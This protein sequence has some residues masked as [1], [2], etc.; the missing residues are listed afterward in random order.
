LTSA[1]TKVGLGSFLFTY[2]FFFEYL[3]PFRR[4]HIPGDLELYHYPLADYAFQMLKQGRFPLW[5]PSTYCGMSFVGNIQAA[6]FYP[7][8]WLMFATRWNHDRLSYQ[9]VETMALAHVWLAFFLCYL[10]LRGNRLQELACMLGAGVFAYSGYL[11]SQL[12]HLGML[13]GYAWIPLGLWGIDQAKERRSW[14]PLWKVAAASALC[15]LAGYPPTWIVFAVLTGFYALGG[16]W[17]WPVAL[18]FAASVAVSLA[19][20][21][22]QVLPTMEATALREPELRYAGTRE[23]VLLLAFTLPNYIDFG[24]N[25]P[26][27]ENPFA[28]YL[29]LGLPG[30]L[31]IPLLIRAR[32]LKRVAP[33]AAMGLASAVMLTNPFDLVGSVVHRS[34]L[35]QDV[36][37]G[38]NLLAGVPL[39]FAAL[40]AFA[41][42][43]FLTRKTRPAATWLKWACVSGLALWA[44][45]DL[46][47]WVGPGFPTGWRASF[48]WMVALLLFAAGLYVVRGQSG[49]ARTCTIA[50]LTVFVGVDYKVF[51]TSKRFNAAPGLGQHYSSA[52]YHAMDT[53]AYQQLRAH[54]QARILLDLTGPL[55]SLVR[56]IGLLTPQ[57]FDPFMSIEFRKLMQPVAHFRSERDFDVYL[58]NDAALQ[59]LGVRYVISSESGPWYPQLVGSPKFRLV[60][61]KRFFY[62]VFEY[63]QARPPYGWESDDTS[64][65]VRLDGWTP[66]Q[67]TF[68]VRSLQGGRF[69]LSEQ[70][71][72]GWTVSID[73]RRATVKRWRG[74]FQAVEAPGGEHTIVFRFREPWLGIGAGISLISLLG[75]AFWVGVDSVNRAKAKVDSGVGAGGGI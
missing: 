44:V 27:P 66:E 73:G 28:D 20:V 56:H 24:M 47:R 4:V 18:G 9:A 19:L 40:S 60:G 26:S 45:I 48:D 65:Q 7:P 2:L 25:A 58:D 37:R 43:S 63:L 61:S 13:T 55:P 5:D 50:A 69:T 16:T 51:G 11:C 23:P 70:F 15:L 71:H 46:V 8:T 53:E 34:D 30:L 1:R 33:A 68:A 3:R 6:L 29:Y 39:V 54:R 22:V 49:R 64:A 67:R 62:H 42:D 52:S 75:L 57:G 74:A 21:A 31:A 36:F 72:P 14:L 12:P 17:R 38:Q 10:W 35:L 41:F 59:L 32:N